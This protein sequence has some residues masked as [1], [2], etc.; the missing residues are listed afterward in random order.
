LDAM[1]HGLPA[2][3]GVAMGVE[4]LLMAQRNSNRIDEVLTFP[5]D[6]A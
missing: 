5:G 6:R 4:R 3:S 1:H 2:C